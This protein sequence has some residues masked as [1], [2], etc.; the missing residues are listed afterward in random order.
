MFGMS[1]SE[2][3]RLSIELNAASTTFDLYELMSSHQGFYPALEKVIGAG[4]MAQWVRP[5]ATKADD[6]SSMSGCPVV[7]EENQVL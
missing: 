5:L 4:Q 2:H 7:E 1:I 3:L 6:L